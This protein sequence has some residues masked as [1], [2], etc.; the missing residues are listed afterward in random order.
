M[1][2]RQCCTGD[3]AQGRSC[4]L[5]TE[6][7]DRRKTVER[8]TWRTFLAGLFAPVMFSRRRGERRSGWDRRARADNTLKE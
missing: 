3:C 1:K 5:R 6:P 2:P 4:P 7:T 8:R